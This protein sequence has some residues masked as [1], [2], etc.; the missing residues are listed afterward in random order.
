MHANYD[1]FRLRWRF[2]F[3]GKP[4]RIGQ[5]SRPADRLEDMAA[6]QNSE[7]LA[8]A[9]IEAQ[10]VVTQETVT[11]AECDGSDFCNFQWVSAMWG[12]AGSHAKIVGL[13]LV[14]R[15]QRCTVYVNG[16]TAV[17]DRTDEDKSFHYATYGR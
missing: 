16:E 6:F 2:D 4:T 17:D 11:V 14:T 3:H 10:D 12:L 15:D 1:A 5:W 9:S 7:G 8:R 13:T